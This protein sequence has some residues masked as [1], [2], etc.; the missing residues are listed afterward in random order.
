MAGVPPERCDA[1]AGPYAVALRGKA[2]RVDP[3]KPTLKASGTKRLTLKYDELL[4]NFAF[5]YN[6]RRYTVLGDACY[7]AGRCR[8]KP[9]LRAPGSSAC[10]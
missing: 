8:F 1:A 5:K 4:S 6:L 7:V 2:V 3:I 10:K 9:V